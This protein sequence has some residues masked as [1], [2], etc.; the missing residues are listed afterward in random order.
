MGHRW[1]VKCNNCGAEITFHVGEEPLN[2]VQTAL[3]TKPVMMR[4]SLKCSLCGTLAEYTR[5]DLLFRS[6]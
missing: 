5:Q 6:A 3:P 2:D 1:I 4:Q